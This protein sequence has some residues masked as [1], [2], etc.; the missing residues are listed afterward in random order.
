MAF[1][2]FLT[3]LD[4][5]V[6]NILMLK[7]VIWMAVIAANTFADN[8]N[9]PLAVVNARMQAHNEHNLKAFLDTYSEDIQVYGYPD[10]PFGTPGKE[11]IQSIFGPLFEN[12]AVHTEIQYQIE[13]GR[14]VVNHET[15][16]RQ[17]ETTVY[18]SIYEVINGKIKSVRFINDQ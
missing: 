2:Q 10:T 6:K 9:S 13:N 14:Y 5:S 4:N 8:V 17:G 12:K 16:V 18:V 7:L 11:H 3:D 15:V 1:N